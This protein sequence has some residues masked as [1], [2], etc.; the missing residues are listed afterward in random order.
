MGTGRDKL[1]SG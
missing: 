1:A